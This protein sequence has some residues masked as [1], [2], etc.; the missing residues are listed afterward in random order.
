MGG[1]SLALGTGTV[2]AERSACL[3]AFLVETVALVWEGCLGL[4]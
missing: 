1:L 2:R 3:V 4:G